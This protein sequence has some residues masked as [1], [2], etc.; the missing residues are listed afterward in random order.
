MMVLPAEMK[1][2]YFNNLVGRF[3]KILPMSES[4]DTTLPSYLK[5][6]RNELTGAGGIVQE[7]PQSS[8][9]FTLVALLQ[10]FI[11]HPSSPI[12]EIK[13]EVFKAI[14]ICKKIQSE[15]ELEV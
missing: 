9:V 13:R 10:F 15:F 11:D 4:N 7:F 6:L 2:Q 1:R 8:E 5:S 3:F 12:S 14:N